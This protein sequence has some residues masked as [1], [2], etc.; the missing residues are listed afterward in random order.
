MSRSAVLKGLAALCAGLAI[1]AAAPA[2]EEGKPLTI[3]AFGDSTT[4][5][6][7]DL[8]V[9][10]MILERELNRGT[11]YA[12]RRGACSPTTSDLNRGHRTG[13]GL[14]LRGQSRGR[15]RRWSQRVPSWVHGCGIAGCHKTLTGI[16][17]AHG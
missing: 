3:V 10:P 4:A 15:C 16:L 7:G 2:G 5:P 12:F 17:L 6:R 14:G 13:L 8:V 1:P 9:Y 11:P